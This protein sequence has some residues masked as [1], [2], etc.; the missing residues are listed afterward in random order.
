MVR[1]LLHFM[2][3]LDDIVSFGDAVRVLIGSAAHEAMLRHMSLCN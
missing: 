1:H 2:R 3:H